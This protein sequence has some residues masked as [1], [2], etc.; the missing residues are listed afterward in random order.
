MKH[1]YLHV[2]GCLLPI[3]LIFLLPALG[4]SQGV[5]FT[6]FIVLM[7]ACHIFM[8]GSH[9]HGSHKGDHGSGADGNDN[10]EGHHHEEG[11]DSG[12]LTAKGK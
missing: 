10:H 3:A 2:I 4:V 5:T 9:G 11:L 1:G 7:F 12:T 6:V 8:M